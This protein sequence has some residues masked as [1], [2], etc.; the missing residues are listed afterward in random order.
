MNQTFQ[1]KKACTQRVC[2]LSFIG[3]FLF[4]VAL[5]IYPAL[6]INGASS[7]LTT[8]SEHT[9][10]LQAQLANFQYEN[11]TVYLGVWLIN[12]YNFQYLTGDYTFDF[13]LYFFWVDPNPNITQI[14]WQLVNGYPIT[15]NAI[16]LIDRNLNS[17]VKHEI[18]RVTAHFNTA[19]N[20]I[21]Y[22]FD[23]I[24]LEV[25][26]DFLTRGNYNNVVWLENQTG[27][28]PGFE[29]SGWKTSNVALTVSSHAYPLDVAV[30][31]ASM[32]I[33]QQRQNLLSSVQALIPPIIFGIVSVFSF[34]FGLKEVSAVG[35]RIGLNTSMLVTTLLFNF[36]ASAAIPPASTISFYGLFMLSILIFMV[37]NLVI[38]I[39]G[40]V[41]W[42]R[43]KNEQQV[44]RINRWG[45]VLA[46]GLPILFFVLLYVLRTA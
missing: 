34:L 42:I 26:L 27:I 9:P 40:V 38:T 33:T 6:A 39:V 12:I 20:A 21:D 18:Y 36:A 8:E 43:Y 2:L 44:K 45:F 30:P 3:I 35:I 4:F 19:P 7:K 46:I 31:R 32:V 41:A 24:K 16:T 5:F 17:T 25:A 11:N 1:R 28:D 37:L 29:N 23:S 10:S 22:P 14:D 13:Y 15:P